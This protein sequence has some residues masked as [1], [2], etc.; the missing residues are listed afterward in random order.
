MK[1]EIPSH[2]M[3][4]GSEGLIQ[5]VHLNGGTPALPHS[6]STSADFDQRLARFQALDDPVQHGLKPPE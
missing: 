2:A 3:G 6:R 1:K 5:A 4:S